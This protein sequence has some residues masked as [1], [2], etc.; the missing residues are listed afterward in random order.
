[1]IEVFLE[2]KKYWKI[3][4]TIQNQEIYQ[5]SVLQVDQDTHMK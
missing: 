3:V 1:M 2:V 5:I 4:I